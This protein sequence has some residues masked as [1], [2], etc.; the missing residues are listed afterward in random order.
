[1]KRIYYIVACLLSL[2][3]ILPAQAQ[4]RMRMKERKHR[5]NSAKDR[6]P[7]GENGQQQKKRADCRSCRSV[8]KI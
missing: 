1:M 8:R 5:S 7:V 2:M 3:T 6:V 4:N